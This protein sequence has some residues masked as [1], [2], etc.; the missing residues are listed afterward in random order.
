[1][2]PSIKA[3]YAE[4]L[5]LITQV[6]SMVGAAIA[7]KKITGLTYLTYQEEFNIGPSGAAVT[8]NWANGQKQVMT[9]NEAVVNVG[10]DDPPGVASWQIRLVQDSGGSRTVNWVTSVNWLTGAEPVQPSTPGASQIVSLFW[11]GSEWFGTSTP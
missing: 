11:S 5:N 3:Q 6:R 1:M 9:L 10:L 7:P 2:S 4:L 8:I